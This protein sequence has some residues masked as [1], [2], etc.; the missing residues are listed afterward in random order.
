M[1]QCIQQVMMLYCQNNQSFQQDK[2]E[3][4][5][6]EQGHDN[7]NLQDT[8]CIRLGIQRCRIIVSKRLELM[9]D[10]KPSNS[11]QSFVE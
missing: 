10:K 8:L 3:T 2:R 4:V 11:A 9:L 5:T 6:L 7:Q 1:N